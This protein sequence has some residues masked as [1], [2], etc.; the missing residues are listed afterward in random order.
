[1][2]TRAVPVLLCAALLVPTGPAAA[3]PASGGVVGVGPVRLLAPADAPAEGSPALSRTGRWVVHLQSALSAAGRARL[4]VVRTDL[5]T[6]EVVLLSRLP[7]GRPAGRNHSQEPMGSLDG[8]TAVLQTDARL[9]A[10]DTD[11]S[12]DAFVRDVDAG[13]TRLVSGGDGSVGTAALSGDGRSAV[14]TSSGTD[15]VPGSTGRN[16]DV[17]LRDLVGGGVQQLTVRPDGSPSRGSAQEA[18]VDADGGTVVFTS[19]ADDLAEADDDGGLLDLF[20][21]DV[22]AGMTRWIGAEAARRDRRA[23]A[24]AGRPL[25]G[26]PRR[27]RRPAAHADQHGGDPGRRRAG[28]ARC[29]P[30]QRR[31]PA[32]R[33]RQRRVGGAARHPQRDGRAAAGAG[34]RLPAEHGAV[35][36]R[37]A[38]GVRVV[39]GGRHP[40]SGRTSSRCSAPGEPGALV[41]QADP[42]SAA[43]VA[44]RP[45]GALIMLLLPP[46]RRAAGQE[47]RDRRYGDPGGAAIMLLLPS[48][49]RSAGQEEHDRRRPSRTPPRAPARAEAPPD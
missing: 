2:S 33:P 49:R 27:R 24:V 40:R 12:F 48:T 47:E 25:G 1:M 22:A 32:A 35:R 19:R 46:T 29:A 43:R 39:P 42:G 9:T 8:R 20:V 3:A 30:V 37:P 41:R 38:G 14:F 21:R 34:G 36:R 44:P 26:Q 5:V 17:Y 15:L 4:R 7:D 6:G 16:V 11:S 18:D 13:V 28:P 31:R 45:P 10:D 23:R